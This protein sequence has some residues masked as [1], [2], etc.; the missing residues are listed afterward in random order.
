MIEDARG[1]DGLE[2][3]VLVIEVAD[4]KA[5]GGEGVGLNIDIGT[6][7]A[8]QETGFSDIGVP[9]NKQ[10]AGIGVDGRQT[11]KMLADLVEVEQRIFQALDDGGH[12]AEGSFLELLAL[13]EGLAVLEQANVVPGYGLNQVLSRRH[14]AEG[15]AEVV[16]IVEGI[17]QVFVKR[18]DVLQARKTLEYGAKLFR[19][20]L[21]GK[22]DL[23]GIKGCH[24]R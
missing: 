13:E 22:L 7:D 3:Q 6:G 9:A 19:K 17:D 18:M 2:A 11:T 4:K 15:D 20:G 23:S 24:G 16:G 5:L 1:V 12:A 14:L 21:L 10:G 8:A